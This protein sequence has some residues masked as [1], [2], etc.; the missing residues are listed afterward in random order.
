MFSIKSNSKCFARANA[1]LRGIL[2]VV[3]PKYRKKINIE[4]TLGI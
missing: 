1:F 2:R 3:L 4:G